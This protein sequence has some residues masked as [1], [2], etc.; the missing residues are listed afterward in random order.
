MA[1]EFR[2]CHTSFEA[3]IDCFHGESAAIKELEKCSH[4][5]FMWFSTN[6][7]FRIHMAMN[8]NVHIYPNEF[9]YLSKVV[10]I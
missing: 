9:L 8:T 6:K 10:R 7:I 1:D 5:Q 3:N 4:K 2:S